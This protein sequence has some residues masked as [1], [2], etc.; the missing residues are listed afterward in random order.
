MEFDKVAS[1]DL[2]RDAAKY[3]RLAISGNQVR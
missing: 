2:V 3:P 1:D